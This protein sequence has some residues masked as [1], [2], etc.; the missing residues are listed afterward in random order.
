VLQQGYLLLQEALLD[1]AALLL[2]KEVQ[3][4]LLLLWVQL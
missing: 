2:S 3:R 4:M 1:Q